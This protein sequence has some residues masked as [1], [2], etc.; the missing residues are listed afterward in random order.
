MSQES[1]N[2]E[3][4]ELISL[5]FFGRL[6]ERKG[7]CT[8]ISA[9]KVLPK[10]WQEKIN[11]IFMGKVVPLYSAELKH[12]NSEQYIQQEL[13]DTISYEIIGNFYS[14]QAIEYI[15]KLD[16]AIVC[17]TSP[18]ENFPN[19][20]LEMGQL[21][22]SL[23]VSDTGGF[24]ETLQLVQ[25]TEG[26]YWFKPKDADSLTEKL[27]E[28][29]TDYPLTP[30]VA[31]KSTLENL[32][33]KLLA[34]K[35]AYI[36]K[37]FAEIKTIEKPKN[38]VTLAIISQN[39]G[40][41]LVDCLSSI[42]AQTY[43]YLDVLIID[44]NSQDSDSK[45]L[46]IHAQSLFPNFKFIAHEKTKGI[47][48]IKNHLL[49]ISG[50]DFFLSFNP[51]VTF[52]PQSIEKFIETAINANASIVTSAQKEIG[53]V[54]RIVSYSGGTLPTMMKGNVYGG[55]CCLFSRALLNKFP[56]TE[57]KD[58]DSQNWE[59]ITAAI[60]TGE[61]I[62]YYPYPLYEYFVTVEYS[63][64]QEM[65]AKAKYS[66]RQF[67]AKIPPEKWTKRQIYMLMTAVQQLQDL[68]SQMSNLQ[69]QLQ[70][71]IKQLQKCEN[72]VYQLEN[73]SSDENSLPQV[74]YFDELRYENNKNKIQE[75]ENRLKEAN[76][77]I[78]AMETS[79]FWSLR[80]KWFKVKKTFGLPVDEE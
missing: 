68:P 8:F 60:V 56:Y 9:V 71:T 67:L 49:E 27:E 33:Q 24:R 17:L 23:V 15:R 41:Y 51:Q 31:E 58:I 30:K 35:I 12:L 55:E 37:A 29:L 74:S 44:D 1:L 61:K 3:K 46:F 20:A 19:T 25:R 65:S 52:F 38:K 64:N 22:V 59:I 62:V 66:L 50:G 78:A 10:K 2:F 80:Q 21:P 79:K 75:L 13:N 5:V 45:D 14:Q 16:H 42:E 53:A 28:A 4:K 39:Q 77:R 26:L 6:E 76:E 7:L 73:N 54:D 63:I 40:K 70:K 47:G 48:A 69:W 43:P 18:Q 11:I 34:E 36:D 32:N 72:H 57:D